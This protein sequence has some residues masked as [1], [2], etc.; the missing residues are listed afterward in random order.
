MYIHGKEADVENGVDDGEDA[1]VEG[2]EYGR[3]DEE[4]SD[5]EIRQVEIL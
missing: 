5:D 3:D 2:G 1:D 4:K